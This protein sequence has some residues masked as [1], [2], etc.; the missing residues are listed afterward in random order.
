MTPQTRPSSTSIY[1]D[2]G[3]TSWPKP[4]VVSAAL[5]DAVV[6]FGG[7]PG[8]GAY[9]LALDTA[10]AIHSARANI[11]SFLGVPDAKDLLFQPGCTQAMNL[12]L[13]GLLRPGDRVV[14]GFAEHN[15]VARPLN[16]LAARGVEVVLAPPDAH[17][18]VDADEVDALVR[19][20]PTRAVVC[21]HAGNL[22]GAIQPVI[23]L[24]DIAHEHE[25]LLLVDGAQAGGHLPVDLRAL[26]ADAWA[27]SGHK[28]LLGPQGIGVLYL[29]PGCDPEELVAGGTG[30]GQ[31]EQPLQPRV[32]PDRYEAGTPNTPG[33]L[34]LGASISWLAEHA[35]EQRA[36]ETA[37][38]RR[39]H[40]GLLALG[41]FRV[42]GPELDEP[43]VPIIAAVHDTVAV[44]RLA[45]ALDRR[46][47][48]ATR[49]GLHCAPWA[50][51]ALGT[52][53]SGALRFGVGYGNTAEQ[54]D[55][56]L[57]A[58]AEIVQDES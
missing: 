30:A 37:L 29:A 43:R 4:D 40:E 56:T 38:T 19:R 34:G 49:G 45:F 9:K 50:H 25:A 55:A 32:R 52:L 44:D 57:A 13:F 33:L 28:G 6:N 26:G 5:A 48:I 21:Q 58:L 8:R 24:A 53:T 47:G 23:D 15:A 39:L 42:L 31:S 14:V 11:A 46:Y 54:I 35:E 1:L 22:T 20:A 41:G 16:M 36:L 12:V 18:I 27:C 17:G 2:H 51:D 7:N 3:A 10:R